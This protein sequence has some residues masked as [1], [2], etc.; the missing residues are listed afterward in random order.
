MVADIK[1]FYDTPHLLKSIRN[2]LGKY[3]LK[4]GN[5][6]VSWKYIE[7]FYEKD[8]QQN[9]KIAPKLSR[10]YIVKE[11]FS[12]MWVNLAAHVLSRIVA[13]GIL[14]HTTLGILPTKAV[15]TAEFVEQVDQ[16]FY[17]FNSSTKYHYKELRGAFKE[18]SSHFKYFFFLQ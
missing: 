4:V 6:V 3:D 7:M 9:I 17:L 10:K 12:D 14:T 8:Q 2:N 1:I 16:L 15:H 5:N 18:N 13:A 11:G